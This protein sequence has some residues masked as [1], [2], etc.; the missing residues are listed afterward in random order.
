[1]LF[2]VLLSF[3]LNS[4]CNLEHCM[5]KKG[6]TKP[7]TLISMKPT[8]I[9]IQSVPVNSPRLKLENYLFWHSNICF[10][11]RSSQG[12]YVFFKRLSINS[13]SPKMFPSLLVEGSLYII[14]TKNYHPFEL[15][16]RLT[17][18]A[19]WEP[20]KMHLTNFATNLKRILLFIVIYNNSIKIF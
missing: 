19:P 6:I 3:K 9:M 8:K 1:M 13:S 11:P 17:N 16:Q 14:Q 7:H 12:L 5:Q 10:S 20:S 18:K 15:L 4:I 2:T